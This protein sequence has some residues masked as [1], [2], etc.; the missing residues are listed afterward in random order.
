MKSKATRVVAICLAAVVGALLLSLVVLRI[1]G[2]EPSNVSG[3]LVVANGMNYFVRPGLWQQGEVVR[4]PV[5]DWSFVRKFSP[6]ALET[7]SPWFVPH[8]VRV[9]AISRDNKLYIPS[10]QY[11]MDRGAA[12]R[13]WTSNVGR[14]PR[15]RMKAGG[16]IYELTLVLVTDRLEA[17]RVWGKNPGYWLKDENGQDRQVGYQHLYRA[18]QRNIPEFNEPTMPRDY[19][20]LPGGRRPDGSL[21]GVKPLGS[22]MTPGAASAPAPTSD[23]TSAPT[24]ATGP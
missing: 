9:G 14:D 15:V 12:D 3:N 23:P 7:E 10:A 2:L 13:L 18:F 16:K 4:T 22:V 24:P 5:T 17:E 1:T 21:T 8:S 20:G 19:S 6:I 11:R